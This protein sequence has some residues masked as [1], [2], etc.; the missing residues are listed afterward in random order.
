MITLKASKPIRLQG[1]RPNSFLLLW[2]AGPKYNLYIP[3]WY[4]LS[5]QYVVKMLHLYIVECFKNSMEEAEE[6]E[7][8]NSMEN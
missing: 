7:V 8:V 6:D 1:S 4:R 2:S 5:I 3:L